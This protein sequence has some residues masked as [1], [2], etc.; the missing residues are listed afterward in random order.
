MPLLSLKIR[1][2]SSHRPPAIYETWSPVSS[3]VLYNKREVG[4]CASW[5]GGI[6]LVSFEVT[7]CRFKVRP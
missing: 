1:R 5:R 4:P 2:F 3:D 7:P 6:G